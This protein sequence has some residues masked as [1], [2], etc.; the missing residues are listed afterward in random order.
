MKLP[1]W[2]LRFLLFA[3]VILTLVGGLLLTRRAALR[4]LESGLSE[5]LDDGRVEAVVDEVSNAFTV[6]GIAVTIGGGVLALL[7]GHVL[8]RQIGRMR[9]DTVAR[10]RGEADPPIARP[11]VA[12]L[13]T[14]AAAIELLATERGARV[15]A[16]TRERDDLALLVDSVSEGMLQVAP[17]GRI[18]H[19]NPAARRLLGLPRTG[20]IDQPVTA[21]VRNTELRSYLQRALAGEDAGSCEVT[22]DDR[23][24]LVDT[25]TIRAATG[26]GPPLGT[27]IAFTDLTEI[28]RLEGVRRDFV[29]NV[30]HE[31]KTPLTSIRGYVET[32][33]TDD[34]PP[35][36]ARQFLGVIHKNAERL[37]GIV[38]DLLD[39][40]RLESGGW[41]P[42][43]EHVEPL[44]IAAE[45][46][47]SIPVERKRVEFGTEGDTTHVIADPSALRQ[48]FSNLL[49]NALRYTPEGGHITVRVTPPFVP[50]SS[51]NG[52]PDEA[53]DDG[54]ARLVTIDVIDTGSGIPHEALGRIFERF[55]RVDPAR[56]RA[57]GGT[58]LGLSIVRHLVE[59][60]GGDVAALSMLGKGTT[61]RIRLPAA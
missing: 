1:R 57:E 51:R 44:T 30:S 58:G 55:Y 26:E 17:D 31:I 27:V 33:L 21:V 52:G 48:I 24:M 2:R 35:E 22:L 28:R 56:S 37:H 46:W 11:P 25:S 53:A 18:V 10:S 39:L 6:T 9:A 15:H 49:D 36:V 61:L 13:H 41:R 40:S 38:D 14:L 16:L 47:D 7:L 32:L 34:V 59:S 43:L 3:L 42:R 12:E 54:S 50:P 8:V 4:T 5:D 29:A 60:M 20:A 23:R 19:A 45:V